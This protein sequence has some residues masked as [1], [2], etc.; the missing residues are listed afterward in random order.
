[1]LE[2]ILAMCVLT[3]VGLWQV[4]IKCG[5]EGWES[6]LPVYNFVVMLEIAKRPIWWIVFYLIPLTSAVV[7]IV[8]WA[9]ILKRLGRG[10]GFLLGVI[11]LP[12]I[13]IPI[14]GFTKEK[15]RTLANA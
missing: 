11:F 3:V 1:M 9:A 5:R 12:F 15:W 4:F 6:I 2:L 14:L 7:H 8:V 13:F 10:T